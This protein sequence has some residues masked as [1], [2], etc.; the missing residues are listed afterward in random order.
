MM[1]C[2]FTGVLLFLLVLADILS[3]LDNDNHT[4]KEDYEKKAAQFH[5]L[6]MDLSKDYWIETM[7]YNT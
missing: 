4:A 6:C 3:Q 2:Q 5:H 1:S 7:Q